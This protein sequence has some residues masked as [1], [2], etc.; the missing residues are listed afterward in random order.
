[1][2]YQYR[3]AVVSADGGAD[4]DPPG[5]DYRPSAAPGCRAPHLWLEP[6][7][8]STI[9]LFDRGHVLLTAPAGAQWCGIVG[10][11]DV[12]VTSHVIDDP[13][14]PVRYG[15]TPSGAVLVRPDG[16][17][18]WRRSALPH[19]GDPSTAEELTA[20]IATALAR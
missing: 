2:G 13:Q 10:A 18:A 16:H 15:V 5:A 6:G 14:W 1:M 20:A 4:A 9:D 3:S 7:R 11:S 12:P 8:L 17:V 19:P